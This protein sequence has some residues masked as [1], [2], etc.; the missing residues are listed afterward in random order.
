MPAARRGPT[1]ERAAVGER[2]TAGATRRRIRGI[3]HTLTASTARATTRSSCFPVNA[4]VAPAS[5]ASRADCTA[6][7]ASRPGTLWRQTIRN[8]VATTAE[9]R[10]PVSCPKAVGGAVTGAET[11]AVAPSAPSP[12]SSKEEERGDRQEGQSEGA[13][14]QLGDPEE[15][16]LGHH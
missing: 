2:G 11:R 7:R 10:R 6:K 4:A 13:R 16:E 9:A 1:R 5:A 15:P 14:E 12:P 3:A 8:A